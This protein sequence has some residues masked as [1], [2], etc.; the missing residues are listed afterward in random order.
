VE[1]YSEP[2]KGSAFHVYLPSV[3]G[4]PE[5]APPAEES[6][7]RGGSETLLVADDSEPLREIALEVLQAQGYHVLLACDGEEAVRIFEANSDKISLVML[8][9]VMPKMMGTDAYE[10]IRALRSGVP[11]IYTSGYSGEGATLASVDLSAAE[12]LQKPY[13][14]K[15]L[16]RKVRELLD[17]SK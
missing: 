6:P 4:A 8:D 1:V 16:A 15:A 3:Q 5:I 17:A 10:R 7:V 12:V 11:V 14:G 2:G 9:I 13:G